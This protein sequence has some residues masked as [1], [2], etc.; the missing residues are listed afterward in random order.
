M[1]LVLFINCVKIYKWSKI[2]VSRLSVSVCDSMLQACM[3][4]TAEDR[5]QSQLNSSLFKN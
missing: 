3:V 4:L 5:R 1:F 2:D